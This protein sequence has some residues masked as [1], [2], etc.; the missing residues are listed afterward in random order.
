ML[1]DDQAERKD[2]IPAVKVGWDKGARA[3][4]EKVSGGKLVEIQLTRSGG[5]PEWDAEVAAADGTAHDVRVDAV[6]GKVT[7]SRAKSGQDAD[8]KAEVAGRLRKARISP[9]Q[10]AAAGTDRKKG[11]VTAVELEGSD[12]GA[13]IWSVDVVTTDDWHKTTFDVDAANGRVLR[14]DVDRD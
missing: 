1:T 6:T 9:Q 7:R 3:A 4:M 12:R 11:T 10:A 5:G 8:D 2:M 13:T 14:E